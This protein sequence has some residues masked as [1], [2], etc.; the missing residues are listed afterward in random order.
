MRKLHYE[1]SI[2][3]RYTHILIDTSLFSIKLPKTEPSQHTYLPGSYQV[4][5]FIFQVATH[6]FYLV[7]NFGLP[8]AQGRL[9]PET[10]TR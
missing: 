1:I 6:S 4:T 5:V 7:V 2:V 9:L 3:H 10:T 8:I